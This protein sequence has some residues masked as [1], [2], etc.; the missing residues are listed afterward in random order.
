MSN[1]WDKGLQELSLPRDYLLARGRLCPCQLGE[2]C[3]LKTRVRESA[4]MALN[5]HKV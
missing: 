1:S 4:K 3:I 5:C 2:L